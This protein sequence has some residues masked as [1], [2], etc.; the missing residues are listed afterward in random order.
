MYSSKS[1]FSKILTRI[2]LFFRYEGIFLITTLLIASFTTLAYYNNTKE[3]PHASIFRML[4]GT[5]SFPFKNRI[6]VYKFSYFLANLFNANLYYVFFALRWITIILILIV[7]R[8]ILKELKIKNSFLP[9]LFPFATLFSFIHDYWYPTDFLEILSFSLMFLLILK[10][11][12][13]LFIIV[14][15]LSFLNRESAIFIL[16]FFIYHYFTRR[17]IK[18]LIFFGVLLMIVILS[19]EFLLLHPETYPV[20]K[21]IYEWKLSKNISFFKDFPLLLSDPLNKKVNYF[22]YRLITFSGMLYLLVLFYWK[23]I[24]K[25]LKYFLTIIGSLNFISALIIGNLRETRILYPIVPALILSSTLILKRPNKFIKLLKILIVIVVIIFFARN[26]IFLKK[27]SEFSIKSQA[28]NVQEFK[29]WKKDSFMFQ[30]KNLRIKK[31]RIFINSQR[32]QKKLLFLDSTIFVKCR[33]KKPLFCTIWLD[34][35]LNYIRQFREFRDYYYVSTKNL[36]F[37][38]KNPAVQS[39]DIKRI[40][41]RFEGEISKKTFFKIKWK[42]FSVENKK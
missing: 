22:F 10:N 3:Y 39:M 25:K 5:A 7:L 42:G 37:E 8:S 40:V 27:D 26:G 16:P 28:L 12:P 24:P 21:K 13:F 29:Q 14:F 34:E 36:K 4:L 33:E 23:H 41:I 1:I 9:F 18:E 2:K 32:I 38:M 17:K 35:D 30:R 31:D 6:L 20:S 15:G 11:K 19:I